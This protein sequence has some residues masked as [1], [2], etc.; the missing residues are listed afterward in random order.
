[1]PFSELPSFKEV[2]A[3]GTAVVLT[4]IGS[5][6][7]G[8]EVRSGC[9]SRSINS[10]AILMWSFITI[11]QLHRHSHVELHHEPSASSLFLCEALSRPINSIAIL[12]WMF[13]TS[14]QLHSHSHVE[15]HHESSTP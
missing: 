12:V 7:R 14:H 13:I 2:A 1:M 10:I 11:H 8:T 6:T 3:C 15:L 9:S 4:P 5:I